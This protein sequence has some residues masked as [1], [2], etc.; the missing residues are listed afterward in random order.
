MKKSV[1][2]F[3]VWLIPIIIFTVF[4]FTALQAD[5]GQSR[6]DPYLQNLLKSA[7]ETELVPVYIMLQERLSLAYLQS[8]TVGLNKQERRKEVVRILKEHAARTQGQVLRYLEDA[9]SQGTIDRIE[10][11][12]SINVIAFS[13]RPSVVSDLAREYAEIE[14]IKYD[15]PISPEEAVDD[16]GISKYNEEN[17]VVLAPTFAPQPG[18]ILINAPAVWAEGDSGQGV[19]LANV[20]GGAD[21]NHPD[22]VRNLWNNLGE[23]A[24]GN[25]QTV[26]QS[27]STWI[28]DPGDING[29]DDDANGKVDDFMGWNFSNNSNDPSTAANSHGTS[30][31]GILVGDGTNGT[32]TGVAPRAKLMDLNINSAGESGWWAAYQYA[33]ENG[34]DVT[35]SSYSAKWY[36]SPQPN[37]PMFRQINDMEL[38]MGTLHTNSTSNDGN[39]TGI[40]F[41][42]SAP[43]CTPGPWIHPDQT[44]V[45]GI[46]SVIG[47]ADV[48]ALSGN[49]VSSSP[50]G[51]WAWEDYQINHPTYPFTMPVAYQDYPY[52][53]IPGSMG[54]IKPDVAAPGSG[55]TSLSPGGGYSSFGG[56]S[57]ATPHLAGTAGLML[58][59][60][61]DLTPEDL[62]RIMQTTAV[63]KG[64]AGKD[65]RY[66]AGLVDAYA[67]YLQAFAE[68]GS[69]F[70]PTD[71]V[72]YSDYQTPTSM[73]L[74][75]VDPTNLV[76]GDTLLIGYYHIHIERDGMLIDSIS[77]GLNQ[78]VDSGLNDG[79]EYSYHIF[80]KVDSSKRSSGKIEASWIAG[81]SPIPQGVAN[82][83]ISNQATELVFRWQNPSR[84]IDGTPMDD[85]AGINL[86]R[87]NNIF[88]TTFART[89]C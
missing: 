50:W 78:F 47:S 61:L 76:N 31:A 29:V 89:A 85:L 32:E 10:N 84:N 52:E 48:N 11:I 22:L 66:G 9:R 88:V 23:D 30:T 65:N 42:I 25:G 21:W 67:A 81:G 45:G 18:L 28:F 35:T 7:D 15:R 8:Q 68:A 16:L 74:N 59:A 49:V 6:I 20:D 34:A 77:G 37:Y 54:L 60:N 5:T 80:C 86:Y 63:E 41:N 72:A 75:W 38:A 40:P 62:S 19:I 17:D 69:P 82:V 39:S 46:S 56:T 36:F 79:Q 58:S 14:M 53:T 57:G 83:G 33:A 44:L 43:G 64:A 71:L 4:N 3:T 26:I 2:I 73:Q 87:D 1:I 51:P 13:A 70:A 24:N 55:T 12:W 27:G